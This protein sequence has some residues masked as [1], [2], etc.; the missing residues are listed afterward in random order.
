MFLRG[1]AFSLG[2]ALA[3][4]AAL[5]ALASRFTS[6]LIIV[7]QPEMPEKARSMKGV[8]SIIKQA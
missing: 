1:I 3:V 7:Y 8:S 2:K 4:L 5:A 6:C